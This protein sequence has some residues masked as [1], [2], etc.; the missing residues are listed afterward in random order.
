MI[1]LKTKWRNTDH[2]TVWLGK[3]ADV[4]TTILKYFW[5]ISHVSFLK[6]SFAARYKAKALPG[7][8]ATSGICV[9]IGIGVKQA[10]TGI[11]DKNQKLET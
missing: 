10:Q 11:T 5:L 7:H 6:E 8:H 3:G 4:Y 9:K 1:F 2:E